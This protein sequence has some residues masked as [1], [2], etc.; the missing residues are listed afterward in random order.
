ML[1]KKNILFLVFF[2]ITQCVICVNQSFA[3]DGQI[4]FTGAIHSPT[5]N[6]DVSS[7][8]QSI[9]IGTFSTTDFQT[10]GTTTTS[11]PVDITLTN[12]SQGISGAKVFF[13]G[14]QDSDNPALLAL[15]D[16]D[17]T[18]LMAS[19]VGV[20]IIDA[21]KKT[22]SINNSVSDLYTLAAGTNT[23]VFYLRYKSTQKTIKAGNATSVMYF[24]L[25]YQ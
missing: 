24:D 9:N 4:N 13:S 10:V 15:E 2:F 14:N 12:C 8:N 1:S 16:T 22:V 18:G 11:K 3:A 20:E 7:K 19:G 23:L 17:N 5:C 21:N 25:Q 6:V